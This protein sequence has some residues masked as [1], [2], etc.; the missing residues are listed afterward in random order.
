MKPFLRNQFR[1]VAGRSG[2]IPMKR[3][4][5]IGLLS[6]MVG[7]VLGLLTSQRN[8]LAEPA[9]VLRLG[10]VKSLFRDTHKTMIQIL[11]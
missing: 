4:R 7:G 11:T 3:L 5:W 9:P 10:L 1:S 2:S 6:G 8:V